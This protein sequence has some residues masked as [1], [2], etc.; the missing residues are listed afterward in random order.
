MIKRLIIIIAFL[1]ISFAI[2]AADVYTIDAVTN[3]DK[4]VID[5]NIYEAEGMLPINISEGDNV[6]FADG[7]KDACSTITIVDTTTNDSFTAFCD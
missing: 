7:N 1:I 3:D 5:G 2:Y 6:I 4:V